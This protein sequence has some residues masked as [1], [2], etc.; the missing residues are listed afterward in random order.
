MC[1]QVTRQVAFLNKTGFTQVI[2]EGFLASICHHMAL[3]VIFGTKHDSHKSHLKGFSIVCVHMTLQVAKH[4][5]HLKSH[6]K[7]LFYM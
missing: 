3:Q 4:N 1:A 7:G 5:S 2:F 6:L